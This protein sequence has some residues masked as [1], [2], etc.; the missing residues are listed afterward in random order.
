MVFNF[1]RRKFL[2][3]ARPHI[4]HELRCY[5]FL[6][7]SLSK[8]SP[9]TTKT[10][11]SLNQHSFTVTYLIS[12][13]GISPES[14]IL[15][16]K[17]LDLSKSPNTAYSVLAFLDNYGFTKSQVSKVIYTRPKLLLFDPETT[18]LPS[19]QTLN[20]LGLS[21]ADIAAIVAASPCFNLRNVF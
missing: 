2:V 1:V 15:V 9:F 12:S 5:G 21:N 3:H 16:S 18:L 8:S 20:S 7:S 17:H 14:A 6:S 19:F 11:G 10:S 4:N 13:C